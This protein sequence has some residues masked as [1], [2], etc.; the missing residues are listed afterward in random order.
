MEKETVEVVAKAAAENNGVIAAIVGGFMALLGWLSTRVFHGMQR[1][2]SAVEAKVDLKADASEMERQRDNIKDLFETQG[3][4]REAVLTAL[5]QHSDM[6]HK[7][8]T[9]LL[10]ELAKRPTREEIAKSAYFQAGRR[11]R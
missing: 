11:E 10:D 8:H 1:R 5:G 9:T 2:L 7:I 4:H 3:K 6:L